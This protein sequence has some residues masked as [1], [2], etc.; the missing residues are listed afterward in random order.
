MSKQEYMYNLWEALNAYD[1]EIRDEIVND[2]E[3]HF[4]MGH[5]AGKSDDEVI[6]ELGSIDEL[7]N[8][9]KEIYGPGKGSAGSNGGAE[10]KKSF[11]FDFDMNSLKTG[12]EGVLEGAANALSKGA[13]K[14]GQYISKAEGDYIFKDVN[15]GE[16]TESPVTA[17]EDCRKLVV[18]ADFGEVEVKRSEDNK[19][20]VYYENGGSITEQMSVKFDFVQEG[21]TAYVR[22]SK[23]A[24]GSNFFKNLRLCCVN[25]G[26]LLPDGFDSIVLANKAGNILVE[27]INVNNFEYNASAGNVKIVNSQLSKLKG[28]NMAGNF[29]VDGC[30]IDNVEV[31]SAA[32]DVKVKGDFKNVFAKGA[33]GNIKI[34]GTVTDSVEVAAN[35]GNLDVILEGCTGYTVEP[36]TLLGNSSF[37]FGREE[38]ND[39]KGVIVFGDGNL[40]IKCKC[41]CGNVDVRA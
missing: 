27:N 38:R 6:K 22:V 11:N 20:H 12:L 14:I 13:E 3:D 37:S 41:Q 26:I 5:Q 28:K 36:E 21:D 33:A 30:K 34:A 1:P 31:H 39:R 4:D 8:D 10:E 25:I 29:N 23:K 35:C 9:L 40:K 17:N 32:G 15:F 24:N 18:E 7:I 16:A 2:Y 19:M